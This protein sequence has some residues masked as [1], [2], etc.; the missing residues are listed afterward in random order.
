MSYKPQEETLYNLNEAAERLRMTWAWVDK[1]VREKKIASV[2]M[3]KNRFI[4]S[5]EI[6]RVMKEGVN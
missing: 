3:G 4:N 5:T 6:A 2:T 1:K